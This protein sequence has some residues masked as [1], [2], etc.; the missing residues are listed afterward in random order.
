[1]ILYING[2]VRDNSRTDFLAKAFLRKTGEAY[3][4]VYLPEENLLPLDKGRLNRRTELIDKG[5]YSDPMFKYAKQF[6]AA[7]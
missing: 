1:M 7:A 3:T 4:E 2:C 5:D 6:A